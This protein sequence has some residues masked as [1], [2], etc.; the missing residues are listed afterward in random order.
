MDTRKRSAHI[1]AVLSVR[2]R[3][4]CSVS[5]P[6]VMLSHVATRRSKLFVICRLAGRKRA[7]SGYSR[8]ANRPT[9]CSS[10]WSE[11]SGGKFK[12]ATW[13]N[14]WKSGERRGG[15]SSQRTAGRCAKAVCGRNMMCTVRHVMQISG[16]QLGGGVAVCSSSSS[17]AP[18]QLRI[19]RASGG[20]SPRQPRPSSGFEGATQDTRGKY[21]TNYRCSRERQNGSGGDTSRRTTMA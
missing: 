2:L 11:R 15:E 6:H 1:V 12:Q 7:R 19:T 16:T 20:R 3:P 18:Q 21:P 17:G 10:N 5:F 14:R 13:R 4:A 8:S 9:L